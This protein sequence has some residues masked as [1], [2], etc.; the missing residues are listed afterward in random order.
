M[1]GVMQARFHYELVWEE[2][3]SPKHFMVVV[4]PYRTSTK[5]LK[6]FVACVGKAICCHM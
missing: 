3:E 5:F 2:I 6:L 1:Y 4:F